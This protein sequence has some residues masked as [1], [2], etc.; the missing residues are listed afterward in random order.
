VISGVAWY[1]AKRAFGEENIP[2]W[3]GMP[4]AYYRDALWIGIGGAA[5][6][7]GLDSALQTISQHWPTAQRAAAAS[8]GSN[9]DAT[10]P[11]AAVLGSTLRHSLLYS[12]L[13][14]FVASFVAAQVRPRWLRYLLLVLGALATVGGNWAG[15]ADFTRQWLAKLIVLGVYVFGVRWVMRNNIFGCFLVLAILSLIEGAAELLGQPDSFYRLNGYCLIAALVL[16]LAWPFLAWR[17]HASGAAAELGPN[18]SAS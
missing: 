14:A 3:T 11:A 10:I 18:A 4:G 16:L 7:L 15:P 9:L 1:Y 8:F 5:G 6:L 2:G 17:R 13:V 12:A